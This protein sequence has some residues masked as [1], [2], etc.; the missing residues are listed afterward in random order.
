[1]NEKLTSNFQMNQKIGKENFDC[2][3]E[4]ASAGARQTS[5]QIKKN[6]F[7]AGREHHRKTM[8]RN[9]GYEQN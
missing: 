1:M 6:D 2:C 8:E 3:Y 4:V 7:V 9:Q 5:S